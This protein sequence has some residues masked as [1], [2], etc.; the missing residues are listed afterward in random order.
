MG[1]L[2]LIRELRARYLPYQ[3]LVLTLFTMKKH[4]NGDPDGADGYIMKDA[5]GRLRQRRPQHNGRPEHARQQVMT[6]LKAYIG[7]LRP[8]EAADA[9]DGELLQEMTGRELDICRLLAE[10]ATNG[11]IAARLYLTEGTVKNYV[12]KIYDKTGIRDRATLAIYLSRILS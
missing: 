4:R 6:A 8:N 3:I 5:A 10:G 1:G 11:E 9:S 7:K 2:E 12:S